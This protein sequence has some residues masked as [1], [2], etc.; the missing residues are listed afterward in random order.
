MNRRTRKKWMKKHGTYVNPRECW[1]LDYTIARFALPRL[2]VYKKD[3]N[4]YPGKGDADT[5]EKWDEILNKMIMAFEYVLEDDYWWRNDPRY[6]MIDFKDE[7]FVT[8]VKRRQ[9]VIKDGLELFA[10]YLQDLWW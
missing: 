1:N 4:C 8:E 7:N 3:C 5:P 10:K 6:K 9:L 2:K